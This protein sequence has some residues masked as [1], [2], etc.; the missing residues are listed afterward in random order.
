MA[1]AGGSQGNGTKKAKETNQP[2]GQCHAA[3]FFRNF[4]LCASSSI[5]GPTRSLMMPCHL[6]PHFDISS[7][8]IKLHILFPPHFFANF[9]IKIPIFLL[10]NNHIFFRK[11][12]KFSFVGIHSFRAFAEWLWNPPL[13]IPQKRM[14][15]MVAKIMTGSA[16]KA[17]DNNNNNLSVLN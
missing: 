14:S 10:S 2:K 17:M 8:F 1:S 3:S 9:F 16:T 7:P 5:H 4:L 6:H 15:R 13:K 12:F 11:N